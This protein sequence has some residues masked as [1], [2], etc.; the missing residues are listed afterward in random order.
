MFFVSEAQS[1]IFRTNPYFSYI[2]LFIYSKRYLTDSICLKNYLEGDLHSEYRSTFYCCDN[3]SY[4]EFLDGTESKTD[5]YL[6]Y[7]LPL[8]LPLAN[9]SITGGTLLP[10]L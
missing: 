6:I 5:A 2:Y 8:P 3:Q 10:A 1:P 7:P 4:C 9:A